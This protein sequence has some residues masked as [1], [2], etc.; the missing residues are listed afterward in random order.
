MKNKMSIPGFTAGSSV[1]KNEGFRSAQPFTTSLA[2]E[3][4][5]VVPARST[6]QI[7]LPIVKCSKTAGQVSCWVVPC[8]I[9]I[10]VPGGPTTL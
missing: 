7:C 4:Q 1:F 5:G 2:R 6:R 10:V 3:S 8:G 9:V